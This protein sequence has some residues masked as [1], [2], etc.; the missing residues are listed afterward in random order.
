MVEEEEEKKEENFAP[1]HLPGCGVEL[2][3]VKTQAE[4]MKKKLVVFLL[5]LVLLTAQTGRIRSGKKLKIKSESQ[6]ELRDISP[7]KH[8]YCASSQGFFYVVRKPLS[9]DCEGQC[10]P[11]KRKGV[12]IV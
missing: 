4:K 2:R 9:L 12:Q 3:A 10:I 8:P 11:Q 5:C 7:L 1:S 6:R